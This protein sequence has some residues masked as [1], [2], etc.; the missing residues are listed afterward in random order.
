MFQEA[1]GKLT[2][3]HLRT[4]LE[5]YLTDIQA[6]YTG[7]DKLKLTVPTVS[8]KTLVG[9]VM[10]ADID[11]LPIIGVDCVEKQEIPSNESLYL[12]QY[13][14]SIVGLVRGQDASQADRLV[15]RYNRAIELF[16]KKHQYLHDTNT[17]SPLSTEFG[18]REFLYTD[19]TFSGSMELELEEEKRV[20]VAGFTCN[21]L[22]FTSEDSYEQH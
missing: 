4:H 7:S 9:G 13:G 5:A 10:S 3:E 20:W 8:D 15:K 22:W 12:Y 17:S 11:E 19:T 14:G 21:V 1:L 2:S 16:V 18:I 6:L